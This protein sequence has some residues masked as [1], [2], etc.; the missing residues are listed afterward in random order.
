MQIRAH[1]PIGDENRIFQTL[2]E[3]VDL[4]NGPSCRLS[5]ASGNLRSAFLFH[6]AGDGAH[7]VVLGENLE[8]RFAH[9]DEDGGILV[10][11]NV[12]DALDGR[13]ARDLR[14]R[15]AHHF[16][17]DELAQIFSLQREIQNLV[18]VDRADRSFSSK[19]GIC[20]MSCCCMVFSA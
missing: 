3:I 7:E 4:Q 16:A 9:F 2:I 20:E 17:D 14:Q 18:F 15:L 10:A 8:A 13:A 19:T 1:R 12:R 5:F 11:Q 6:E